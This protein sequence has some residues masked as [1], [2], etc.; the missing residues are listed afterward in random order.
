MA[1]KTTNSKENLERHSILS[2]K[3]V[4]EQSV[5]LK[6]FRVKSGKIFGALF[7][8]SVLSGQY[9]ML[10]KISRICPV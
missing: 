4:Q 9:Q 6:L 3:V 10:S 8:K 5:P 1:L 7:K 2:V